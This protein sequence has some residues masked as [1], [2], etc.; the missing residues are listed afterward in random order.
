[1]R[2]QTFRHDLWYL[3]GYNSTTKHF[4]WETRSSRS[5]AHVQ[6]VLP[7]FALLS[8]S[9]QTLKIV[10]ELLGNERSAVSSYQPIKETGTEIIKSQILIQRGPI[11]PSQIRGHRTDTQPAKIS[12]VQLRLDVHGDEQIRSA[13]ETGTV[14]IWFTMLSCRKQIPQNHYFKGSVKC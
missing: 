2:T 5:L 13:E 12:I 9:T 3:E 10:R 14:Q 8:S 1:M 6:S 7:E 11:P 4:K